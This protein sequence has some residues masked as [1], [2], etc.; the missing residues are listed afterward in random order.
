MACNLF[1]YHP[2]VSQYVKQKQKPLE[3]Y[4]DMTYVYMY[5]NDLSR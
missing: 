4:T 5:L 3:G 1:S 2:N